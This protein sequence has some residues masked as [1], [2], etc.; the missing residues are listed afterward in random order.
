MGFK[1][2]SEGR[3]FFKNA[4]NDDAPE[5]TPE[6]PETP[7]PEA[8]MT[9]GD[10]TQVQ[11]LLMLKSLNVKLQESREDRKALK[12]QL[13]QYKKAISEL[14]GRTAKHE[15]NY[16]DLEQ[17]VARK[18]TETIKK[19]TR[20]EDTVKETV[21]EF[22]NARKL[23]EALEN[24]STESQQAL[25]ALK[26]ETAKR[27]ELEA[28]L[29]ESAAVL[30]GLK[31]EL[32]TRKKKDEE[33]E[34]AAQALVKRQQ[35]LEKKQK[36]QNEKMVDNVAAYV[37][38]TKRVNET[39]TRQAALDNKIED[40]ASEYLKLDRKIDKVIDDR[41]RVLRKIE[42]VEEAVMQTRDALN[43]KAMVLLTN[44]GIAGIDVPQIAD[45]IA[46]IDPMALQR[47]M[48][49][50]AVMPW[51]RRPIR[52]HA[53]AVLLLLLV[54]VLAGWLLSGARQKAANLSANEQ[55][56][57]IALHVDES[58]DTGVTFTQASQTEEPESIPSTN[59][60][61]SPA[62]SEEAYAQGSPSYSATKIEDAPPPAAELDIN[63]EDA[64]L[65]AMDKNP[66][67]VAERMNAIEPSSLT[68]GD[69]GANP[70]PSNMPEPITSAPQVTPDSSNTSS[71]ASLASLKAR[72]TPDPNLPEIAKK[73]EAQAFQ[74]VPEAQHDM[75]ALYVAGHGQVKQDLPRAVAWFEEAAK[76]GVSNAK[77][78]LGV[79][80]HQGMGVEKDIGKAINLY[81][82]AAA[83]GHPEAQY[84]LG[85]A[86]IEGVG[87]PYNP[88]KAADYFEA[89]ANKGVVEAAYNLG[90][91]Y[92]NGL[93]GAPRPDE[94][95]MW[96]KKAADKGSPEARA[97]L[98]Q[99]ASSIGVGLEDVNRIVESVQA[100]KGQGGSSYQSTANQSL[101]ARIQQELMRLGLY[102]GPVD[103]K[104]G[105]MT[106][107][108]IRN[109]QRLAK[110][111]PDGIPS[112]ALLT[113]LKSDNLPY[114]AAK[115]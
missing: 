66:Q 72:I 1:K 39:E 115:E 78:N 28:K 34:Q 48:Q 80:Y 77:Y 69:I 97:A 93:L 59:D 83:Q 21:K 64:M 4:D 114:Q 19:A 29:K 33:Q 26:T 63:D 58:A 88:Q 91:I 44:Q 90:L 20:V 6:T 9:G 107:D 110:L 85:I 30:D 94:A 15:E 10:Q 24:K 55:T 2:T 79:L 96:Y 40:T 7:I 86:N 16:I 8:V 67:D 17:K 103:G 82:D 98:E 25:S 42:R 37:A 36:E 53:T 106:A 54:G 60:L 92:E 70:A 65:A 57:H 100:A 32:E 51:W 62:P 113:A 41:M 87:V 71:S 108:A 81:T 68:S 105:P 35:E 45:K 104:S 61:L 11:I 18:Q 111:T 47:R 89:A 5:K 99:L 23:L 12:K 14:E 102:P 76:N 43:A 22:E 73:I 52:L 27:K 109:F 13:D 46:D 84:N 101:I 95:L 75:G 112:E 38:L 74:G 56:P 49:E 50:E 31:T 3:V